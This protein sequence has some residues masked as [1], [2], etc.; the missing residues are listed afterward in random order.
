VL[1]PEGAAVKKTKRKKDDMLL[2]KSGG[3]LNT[4]GKERQ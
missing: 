3:V 1:R 4:E 2:L